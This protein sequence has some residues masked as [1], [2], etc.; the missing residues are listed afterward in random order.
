MPELT[1]LAPSATGPALSSETPEL[2]WPKGNVVGRPRTHGR[3]RTYL[4]PSCLAEQLIMLRGG[5]LKQPSDTAI[6]SEEA[7]ML[8]A[9]VDQPIDSPLG[10]DVYD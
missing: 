4:N 3:Q 8:D 7:R 5:N 1:P 9:V 6:N 2:S 10:D